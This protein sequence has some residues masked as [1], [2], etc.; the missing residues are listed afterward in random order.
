MTTI[1][2]SGLVDEYARAM[3]LQTL[4]REIE[5]NSEDVERRLVE[6]RRQHPE[7]TPEQQY[8]RAVARELWFNYPRLRREAPPELPQVPP[9]PPEVQTVILRLTMWQKLLLYL[10]MAVALGLLGVIAARGQGGQGP[11][12]EA[13]DEGIRVRFFAAGVFRWNCIGANIACTWNAGTRRLDLTIAGGGAAH[14]LLSATHT[15]TVAAAP[16]RG[17]LIVA[18]LAATWARLALGAAGEVPTSNGLDVVYATPAGYTLYLGDRSA[19]PADNTTYFF[20]LPRADMTIGS[21]HARVIVPRAGVIRRVVAT[22]YTGG[23][24]GTNEA[25]SIRIRINDA[26]DVVISNAVDNSG[27]RDKTYDSGPVAQAV[28]LGDLINGKWVTPAGGW[29]TNPTNVSWGVHVYIE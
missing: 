18:N 20:G 21:T 7:D 2:T 3:G 13:L 5:L 10:W 8:A 14:N 19:T 17:D 27:A 6:V 12:I 9:P 28:A 29:G 15:D 24:V 25:S 23:T 26:V 16:V 11:M 22:M 4:S 1:R